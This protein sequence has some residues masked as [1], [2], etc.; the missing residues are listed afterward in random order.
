MRFSQLYAPTMRESPAEAEVVSHQLL[1]KAGF[2]RKA[3]GGIY[4]YL[5]LAWRVLRK[6]EQ[7]VREEM[8]AKG[9]Q[10]IAMPIVQPAEVWQESGRW[11]VYGDEMFRLRDRHGR[12]FCLGPTHEEIVTDLV[13]GGVR[14]YRQL[15]LL[16]YQIQNKY[17]DETRPRFGLLR[18]REFIMKDLYSFDRD[19]AGLELSYRKMYDAYSRTFTRCGLQFRPVEADSGA[20][21]GSGSHEFMVLAG[22]GEAEIVYCESCDFAANTEK[23]EL[24]PIAA[25]EE[26]P[27]AREKVSTPNAAT[28]KAVCGYLGIPVEKSVKAVAYKS[29]KGLIL[30]FVRGDHEVNEVKVLNASGALAL[31]KAG[32]DELRAAGTEPGYMGLCPGKKNLALIAD[33]SVMNMRNFVCG[34]DVLGYHYINVNPGRDFAPDFVADIRMI[35][36]SDSCQRCGGRLTKARGIEVGQVFKLHTKYS[37][38]LS[39]NYL[40]ESGKERPLVMGCYGIGISRVMAA[41]I[42]Q[43]HDKDGIIWPAAIAPYQVAVVPVNAKDEAQ[44]KAAEEI[45]ETL[46]A[47]GVETVL[48]DRAERAGVKFNDADLIGYPLR[49]TVGAKTV[50]EKE[51][52]IKIRASGEVVFVKG[53]GWPQKIKEL[54]AA[55]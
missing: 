30:A 51:L 4:T 42:E 41:V 33:Q 32:E 12:E 25:P 3:A 49:I 35:Q 38:K 37:E 27:L 13:K 21:G 5:P 29:D 55:L 50:A 19:G 53:G 40:D 47:A 43:S 8:D 6:I 2:V 36:E 10:E 23:A 14:S 46:V 44:M 54:L 52:E 31:S 22:S 7:I 15:P 26:A 34:A 17:R 1:L 24:N 45:Y 18:G 16:L 28:I 9:G 39:A 48:D 20:I 11:S